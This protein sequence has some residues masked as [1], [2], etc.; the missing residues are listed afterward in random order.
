MRLNYRLN[1]RQLWNYCGCKLRR[2][3]YK[4]DYWSRMP[5]FL[6]ITSGYYLA[7]YILFFTI[8]N[9]F[10]RLAGYPSI[11]LENLLYNIIFA[12]FWPV[13]SYLV[14]RFAP[15]YMYAFQAVGEGR[16]KEQT[17]VVENGYLRTAQGSFLL[18]RTVRAEEKAGMLY[19]IYPMQ[20][21]QE[22]IIPIPQTVFEDEQQR[23]QFLQLLNKEQENAAQHSRDTLSNPTTV[24]SA[25]ISNEMAAKIMELSLAYQKLRKTENRLGDILQIAIWILI[26][27]SVPYFALFTGQPIW[28][29][30]WTAIVLLARELTSPKRAGKRYL[31]DIQR[32]GIPELLGEWKMWCSKEGILLRHQDILDFYQWQDISLLMDTDEYYVLCDRQGN[33]FCVLPKVLWKDETPFTNFRAICMNHGVKAKNAHTPGRNRGKGNSKANLVVYFLFALIM[34]GIV[35]GPT[36]AM[37]PLLMGMV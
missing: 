3:Q 15:R 14:I 18:N 13:L 16:L 12:L 21:A 6:R 23:F 32:G 2:N 9:I 1:I 24:I 30:T 5:I 33:M 31:R 27:I 37:I 25:V 26:G 10:N 35:F 34:S 29:L 8:A 28:L 36:L 11:K 17:L 19:L 22:E 4:T 20:C 7:G